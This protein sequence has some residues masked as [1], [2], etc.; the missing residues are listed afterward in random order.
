MAKISTFNF[1]G[2]SATTADPPPPQRAPSMAHPGSQQASARGDKEALARS[3]RVSKEEIVNFL[4]AAF[5]PCGP[6]QACRAGHSGAHLAAGSPADE[7]A[8]ARRFESVNEQGFKLRADGSSF[9]DCS[10]SIVQFQDI[11]DCKVPTKGEPR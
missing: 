10:K 5:D 6:G 1:I 11:T 3:E 8:E 2:L 4:S 7:S 9:S